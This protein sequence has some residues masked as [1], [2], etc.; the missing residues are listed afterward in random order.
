MTDPGSF[1]G[2]MFCALLGVGLLYLRGKRIFA[3]A[4]Q[5]GTE[6]FPSFM[7]RLTARSADFLLLILGI[8][9]LGN[10]YVLI[11]FGFLEAWGGLALL[12]LLPLAL[13]AFVNTLGL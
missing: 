8:G 11:C 9:L 2:G 12:P 3:R 7:R 1:A 6:R 13:I 4:N 5:Y 10:A